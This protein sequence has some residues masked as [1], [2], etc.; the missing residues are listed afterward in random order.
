M[1]SMRKRGTRRCYSDAAC[2]ARLSNLRSA[3]SEWSE[4]SQLSRSG[5]PPMT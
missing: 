3:W 4:K 1:A 5:S 2:G